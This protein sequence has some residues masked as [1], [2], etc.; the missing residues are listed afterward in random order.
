MSHQI[1]ENDLMMAVFDKQFSN[2]SGYLVSCP[3]EY[4]FH[5]R[6]VKSIDLNTITVKEDQF[7]ESNSSYLLNNQLLTHQLLQE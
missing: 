6:S 3:P 4:S 5:F 1:Q 2:L 7:T